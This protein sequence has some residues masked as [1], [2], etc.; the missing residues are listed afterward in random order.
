M[1]QGLTN[2]ALKLWQVRSGRSKRRKLSKNRHLLPFCLK[3]PGIFD[4]QQNAKEG[5]FRLF[6]RSRF[7]DPV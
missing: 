1:R 7:K 4:I 6:L 2:V 3:R 5:H